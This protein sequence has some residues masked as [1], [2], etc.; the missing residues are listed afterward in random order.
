MKRAILPSQ[1][2][3]IFARTPEIPFDFEPCLK[4]IRAI[5]DGKTVADSTRAML[6]L[7]AGH[8]PV[9]YLP[10]EDVRTDLLEKTE[11][12]THRPHKGEASYWKAVSAWYEEGRGA[13]DPAMTGRV[14]IRDGSGR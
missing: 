4:R 5:H 13:L 9:Y 3:R 7:E 8:R 12:R 10:P 14:R 6:M 1:E 11:R 2:E